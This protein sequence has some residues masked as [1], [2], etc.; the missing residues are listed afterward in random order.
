MITRPSI[1]DKAALRS[2]V[3][4]PFSSVLPDKY[5][6]LKT[7]SETTQKSCICLSSALKGSCMSCGWPS[8]RFQSAKVQAE[9]TVFSSKSSDI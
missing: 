5:L 9:R 2:A 7:N 6:L 3:L 4:L 8:M 1:V